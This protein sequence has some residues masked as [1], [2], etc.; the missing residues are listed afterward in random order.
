MDRC[1][2]VCDVPHHVG[3]LAMVEGR[4]A[5]SGAAVGSVMRGGWVGGRGGRSGGGS[6]MVDG[7]F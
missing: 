5:A 1:W 2:L 4:V 7:F 6:A 3:D